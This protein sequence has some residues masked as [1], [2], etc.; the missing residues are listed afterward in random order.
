M[1]NKRSVT[2]FMQHLD[3]KNITAIKNVAVEFCILA[4]KET[5]DI[6]LS[7]F[8]YGKLKPCTK[9][10]K[11]KKKDITDPHAPITQSQQLSTHGQS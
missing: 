11:K 1:S 8:Y 9:V 4:Q 3:K 10:K 6:Y 2:L 5:Q 7:L